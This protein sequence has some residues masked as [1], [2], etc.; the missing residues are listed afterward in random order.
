[1][2]SAAM[3]LYGVPLSPPFRAVAW[4]LLQKNVPFKIQITVPGATNKIGSL[5]DS[6]LSKTKSR[7]GTVPVLEEDDGITLSESPAILTYICE[8]HQWSDL[9]PNQPGTAHKALIDSYLH[10]H[11]ENTRLIAT[12]T[13]PYTRPDLNRT[14]TQEQESRVQSV[15]ESLDQGWLANDAYIGGSDQASV[16][17]LLAYEEIAQASMT[18]VLEETISQSHP[19]LQAWM[20]RM[21]ALPFHDAAHA[22]LVALG[23]LKEP[24]DDTPMM[25]RLGA[26]T[27]E[28]MKALQDA[29]QTYVS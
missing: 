8:K 29:Q 13:M 11:H 20:N 16:A 14:C 26:A 2:S 9:Y 28:G 18:G 25:K 23:N 3:K 27:K 1:M 10:W 19:N 17:D 22:S 5:H 7:S 15:L 24:A 12:L 21:E 6:F 4:T